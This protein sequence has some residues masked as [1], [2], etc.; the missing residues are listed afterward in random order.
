MCRTISASLHPKHLLFSFYRSPFP[1][2]L[3]VMMAMMRVVL[4]MKRRTDRERSLGMTS[5][6]SC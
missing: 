2:M 4:M 5:T 1:Q 6:H 3:A